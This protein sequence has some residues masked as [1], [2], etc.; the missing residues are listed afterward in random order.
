MTR[1][2]SDEISPRVFFKKFVSSRR[3]AVLSSRNSDFLKTEFSNAMLGQIVGDL[4]VEV[5]DKTEGPFGSTDVGSRKVMRFESEFLSSLD[6][7]NFYLTT[8]EVS[9]S[10]G[11][12]DDFAPVLVRRLIDAGLVPLQLPIAG[13]L[14]L[15]NVNIWMGS[16]SR[17]T[18]SG[19]H[20]DFHDNFYFLIRGTKTFRLVSPDRFQATHGRAHVHSNGFVSYIPGLRA[21]G[22]DLVDLLKLKGSAMDLE[23]AE[24]LE[25]DRALALKRR[26]SLSPPNFC[27][28]RSAPDY[29]VEVTLKAGEILYLPAGY[30]HEVLSQDDADEE[31]HLAFNYWYHPP[32]EKS[33]DNPYPDRFWASRA[34]KIARRLE[35]RELANIS[36]LSIV[37]RLKRRPLCRHYTKQQMRSFLVRHL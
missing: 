25:L 19:F 9:E 4:E 15:D 16:S 26:K 10:R 29:A 34:L 33:F 2:W 30:F 12:P 20:H 14:V 28:E 27:L 21:D 37:K 17:K 5:E 11:L 35:I 6:T 22:A 23:K 7:G 1:H 31:G 13:N 3:P 36:R 24:E 32:S 8:Q 18:S